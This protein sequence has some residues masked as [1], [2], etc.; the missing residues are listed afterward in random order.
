MFDL[1][2]QRVFFIDP[3]MD[4]TVYLLPFTFF[5]F[6]VTWLSWRFWTFTIR[7]TL[8]PREPQELPYWIPSELSVYVCCSGYD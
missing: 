1:L 2:L 7:P 5:T 6:A 8:Q 4:D 3:K